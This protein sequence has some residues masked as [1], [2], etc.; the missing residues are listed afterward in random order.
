MTDSVLDR[1]TTALACAALDPDLRGVLLFDLRPDL[2]APLGKHLAHALGSERTT[3]LGSGARED[4]LWS[5]PTPRAGSGITISP[6]PLVDPPDGPPPVVV[7]GDLARLGL[8]ERRAAITLLDGDV[9]HL[10]RDGLSLIWTPRSRWLAGCARADVGRVSPHLLDRFPIR[11][12]A[13]EL[14]AETLEAAGPRLAQPSGP[15]AEVPSDVIGDVMALTG[16]SSPGMRRELALLRLARA[17]ATLAGRPT[18]TM[19]D[20]DAAASLIG[21]SAGLDHLSD[22][23]QPPP[24][25]PG[26]VL[27]PPAADAEPVTREVNEP[28][29]PEPTGPGTFALAAP[30]TPYPEDE[31][32]VGREPGTLRPSPSHKALPALNGGRPI[33]VRPA[34][35]VDDIAVVATFLEAA[36]HQ[37]RRCPRHFTAG[38]ATHVRAADLRSYRRGGRPNKLLALVLDHTC[39]DRWDWTRPLAPYL[40]W[41]YSGRAAVCVVEVGAQDTACEA[42]AQ[43]FVAAGLLDPRVLQALDR[44]RG[45]CTPLAHGLDLVASLLRDR[46]H[47]GRLPSEDVL[48]V[49]VT[50]GRGN[51]PLAA[52]RLGALPEFAGG[53][54]FQDSL[55]VARAIRALGHVETVVVDPGPRHNA[56]LTVQL[57][58]ALG[59]R[60]LSDREAP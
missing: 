4:T 44:P 7:V 11:I 33:G 41:A 45:R 31:A 24:E 17:L 35:R 40:Q 5:R 12:D 8:A 42:R 50:D 28:D 53:E 29:G 16:R 38:H 46:L 60:L 25:R 36:R 27:G 9:A 55:H 1:V 39:H 37:T 18:T 52:S 59:A 10:E 14:T 32:E 13:S 57:S 21:L 19:G 15:P 47:R 34:D 22:A 56:R 49:V 30:F 26:D 48:L 2:A 58:E 54:G 6:G 3:H 51:V 20:V 43:R 23:D